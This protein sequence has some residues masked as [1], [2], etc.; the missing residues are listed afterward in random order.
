M[1]DQ[2]DGFRV[3]IDAGE[4][5]NVLEAPREAIKEGDQVWISDSN[6][7][8]QIRA[9]QV[10]WRREEA[11]YLNNI[12]ES[13]ESIIISPLRMALPGMKVNPQPA[14]AVDE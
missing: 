2:P 9:A 8:L 3:E 6:N 10:L 5:K 13:G 4:L 7:E 1:T 12:L 11:V 14:G